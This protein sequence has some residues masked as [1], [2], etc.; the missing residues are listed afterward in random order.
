[1]I[2]FSALLLTWY[3]NMLLKNET[4]LLRVLSILSVLLVLAALAVVLF[5]TPLEQTMGAVQKVFYFHLSAAWVGMLAF[6][7]A[8]L[9][10]IFYLRKAD[11]KW[12]RLA[13]ASVEIGLLFTVITILSG[14]IWA[15]PIWNTWWTWDPR[16]TTITIMA[17]TYLG[18]LLLRRSSEEPEKRARFSA[19]YAVLG[20]LSVPLTFL[21]AH[22]LRSIH[23]V[24]FLGSSPEMAMNPAM[25]RALFLGLFSFSVLYLALLWQRVRLG[26][27][28]EEVDSLRQLESEDFRPC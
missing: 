19:I 27:L 16:L 14:M 8:A 13:A 21:S 5:L 9:F 6:I 23:P 28:Q 2:S 1:M 10:G 20:V 25:Y 4:L 17:F 7:L 3:L 22:L 24:I 12:D 15:R 18:Y 26:R 11:L